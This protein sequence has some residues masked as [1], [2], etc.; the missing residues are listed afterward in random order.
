MSASDS[1]VVVEPH[2]L[3]C[4]ILTFISPPESSVF[5]ILSSHFLSRRATMIPRPQAKTSPM[6]PIDGKKAVNAAPEI[7]VTVAIESN[8]APGDDKK[9]F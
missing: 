8:L 2:F 1:T 3:F 9:H 7:P 4:P 5:R 6:N